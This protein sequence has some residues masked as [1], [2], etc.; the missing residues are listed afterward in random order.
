MTRS[1]F[2]LFSTLTCFRYFSLS[3]SYTINLASPPLLFNL[4]NISSLF[5]LPSSLNSIEPA[6]PYMFDFFYCFLSLSRYTLKQ[7]SINSLN[8]LARSILLNNSSYIY[9]YWSRIE[10]DFLNAL[11]VINFLSYSIFFLRLSLSAIEFSLSTIL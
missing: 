2:L 4:G 1:S 5:Y 9:S 10:L 11:V 7:S 8:C 3:T 6:N